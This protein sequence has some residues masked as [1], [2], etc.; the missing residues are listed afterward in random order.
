MEGA[1]SCFIFV[2]RKYIC[3][4]EDV[5]PGPL[6]FCRLCWGLEMSS[7]SR[8]VVTRANC[9]YQKISVLLFGWPV[10]RRSVL[11][12]SPSLSALF[13]FTLLL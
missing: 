8:V 13:A 3:G 2:W 5:E 11:D 9:H 10:S 7:M 1:L 4:F 12:V 6:L